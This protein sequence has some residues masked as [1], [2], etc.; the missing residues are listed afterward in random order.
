MTIAAHIN[1]TAPLT[2]R[3][4]CDHSLRTAVYPVAERVG[5]DQGRGLPRRCG[6]RLVRLA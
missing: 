3:I 6:P 5:A 4:R 1:G 2:D